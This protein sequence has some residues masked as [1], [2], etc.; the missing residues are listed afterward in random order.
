MTVAAT[1]PLEEAL[2]AA[3]ALEGKHPG[4]KLV[5]LP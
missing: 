1:Y 2:V 3:E 4:G 5:L